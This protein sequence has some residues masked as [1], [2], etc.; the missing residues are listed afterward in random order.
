MKKSKVTDIGHTLGLSSFLPYFRFL[1]P[2]WK[3]FVLALLCG[4][5]YGVSSG[6]GLPFMIDQV[7]PQIFPDDL[8]GN[9]TMSF[10]ERFYLVAWFP[11]VFLIR[12]MSGYF[13]SYFINYCGLRVL[14]KIR[15]QVF[16]KLQHL[17]VSFFQKNKE[18]DLLSRV[19]SDTA[20]L[21][22]AL[23][24]VSNDL[25]RQPITFIGALVALGV[26]AY[27]RDGMAFVLL[28][29]AVI[30]VCVFPIRR[31]GALLMRKAL[32][33]QQKVGGMTAVLSENL[34]AYR[35]VR[36]FNLEDKEVERFKQS[37]EEFLFARMKV[38]KYSNLLTPIIEILTAA[39]ISV[40]IFHASRTSIRLDA[41]VP[42]ITALYIAY[43]PVKKL[44]G[45]HNKIKE[46]LASLQRLNEILF[47]KETVSESKN[48]QS[49][50]SVD[51]NIEFKNVSFS[52]ESLVENETTSPALCDLTF[53]VPNGQK[54]AIVGSSGAGKSTLI[55]MLCRFQD[56]TSGTIL[57]DGVDLRN[58][59]LRELRE[60]IALVPQRPFLF[61]L[62]VQENIEIGKSSFTN[63]SCL[64]AAEASNAIN[65][66]NSLPNNFEEKLGEGGCRLSGGQMQRLAIAR[67][68]YRNSP[69]L[70]LDE[71][72]SALD[73]ENEEKIKQ[74]MEH[75]MEGK[76]AFIIAHRFST[77]RS[78]D[79]ILVMERGRIIADGP[80][81]EIYPICDVYRKLFDQQM[82]SK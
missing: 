73:S 60:A 74:A 42:V 21:Q 4:L 71:A 35:E 63:L 64:E 76:T 51:Q 79:R 9:S 67:A 69:V 33:M 46:G 68:F 13:N 22:S 61:D 16:K 28:C 53:S 80:H 70:V 54:I 36:A 52:Y 50:S 39:G 29:L 32:G 20:Q 15:I 82:R 37:S 78:V 62:S 34:S 49:I 1:R 59:K 27:Q 58:L 44:G 77:I 26:M 18:G 47:A 11:L 66:I 12:G 65:F 75:L 24:G 8:E 48:A 72:T 10:L 2:H 14:E 40:A 81:D 23:L 30:P 19:T 56:P 43:D 41:V 6:F 5:V 7:F 31:I 3:P 38:V 25:V 17:P 57:I 55:N 45:I